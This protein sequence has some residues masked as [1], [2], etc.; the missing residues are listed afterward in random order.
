MEFVRRT[1]RVKLEAK[2]RRLYCLILF[3]GPAPLEEVVSR[4]EEALAWARDRSM[5]SLEARAL[6]TLARTAAM[7]GDFDEA[8]RLSKEARNLIQDL[9]ELLTSASDS[10]SEGLIELLADDLDAAERALRRGHEALVRRGARGPLAN[11]AANLARVLLLKERYDEAE[12]L[13]LMCR[14]IA[15]ESQLDTQIKWRSLLAVVQAR[16]GD[17]GAALAL[18]RD[19]VAWA[20][21]SEQPDSQAEAFVDLAE[22]LRA[23]GRADEA[24]GYIDRALRLYELKGNLVAAEQVRADLAP[25]APV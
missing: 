16:R 10:I 19:A 20:E 2:I 12:E 8:R 22:I 11:V 17:L 3:W 5:F 1:D 15:A 14:E 6:E 23:T 25:S 13:A 18:A 4:N 9:G 21:R 24:R 7:R